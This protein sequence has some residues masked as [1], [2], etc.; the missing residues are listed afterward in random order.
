MEN[1]TALLHSGIS[2]ALAEFER[3][4]KEIKEKQDAL[5][6]RILE[7][8]ENNGILK[9]DTDDLTITYVA[10]TSRETFDSKKF[11]KDNP[12]MYDEYVSISPVKASI[13]M[14]VK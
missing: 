12:D 14:K 2:K 13:R 11:R 7:E 6:Q 1:N 9:I 10:P 4:A 5:K 3:Q 8:M